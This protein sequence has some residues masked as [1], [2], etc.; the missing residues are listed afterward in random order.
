MKYWL[1][2]F[3]KRSAKIQ[4]TKLS[5]YVQIQDPEPPLPS[6]HSPPVFHS[7]GVKPGSVMFPDSFYWLNEYDVLGPDKKSICAWHIVERVYWA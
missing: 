7:R 6:A 4:A 1:Y 2:C 3:T 5:K